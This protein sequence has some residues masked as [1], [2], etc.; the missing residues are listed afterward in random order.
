MELPALTSH[1][2]HF[3][4]SAMTPINPSAD[5]HSDDKHQDHHTH[6][7]HNHH[8]HFQNTKNS[9]QFHH[10]PAVRGSRL[11]LYFTRLLRRLLARRVS[12]FLYYLVMVVILRGGLMNEFLKLVTQQVT[13]K[14]GWSAS[15]TTA[16]TT[17]VL[18]AA[19]NGRAGNRMIGC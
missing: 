10:I 12:G 8:V 4:L 3:N 18:S 7:H 17:A 13:T 2:H 14:L 19:L 6:H 11:K 5:S 15:T 1:S 9:Q 16:L